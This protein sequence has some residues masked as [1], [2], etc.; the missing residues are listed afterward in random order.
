MRLITDSAIGYMAV[1]AEAEGEP[2]E[3]KCAVAEVIR[4]RA[5]RHYNSD[6]TIAGTIA[7]RYQFSFLNDDAQD[8][9]RLIKALQLDSDDSIVLDCIRAW[10]AVG[11]IGYSEIVPGAVLYFNPHTAPAPA[12][13]IGA[14]FVKTV[15]NH[16]F[17]RDP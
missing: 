7:R 10:N 1:W 13:A 14:N 16:A 12:W 9:L 15:G 2:Y 5:H 6:G 11:Q 3:G 17:Y 4:R 8:N